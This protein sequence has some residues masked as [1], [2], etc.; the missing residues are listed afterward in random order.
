MADIP[1]NECQSSNAVEC[2]GL[3]TPQST[4]LITAIQNGDLIEVRRLFDLGAKI[5]DPALFI[6]ACKYSHLN[7]VN[8]LIDSAGYGIFRLDNFA[9]FDSTVKKFLMKNN[10][11]YYD[12]NIYYFFEKPVFHR[13]HH[14]KPVRW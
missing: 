4:E 12:D 8:W 6:I 13:A 14:T 10:L 7:I 1:K 9:D 11:V 5:S 2:D 3:A